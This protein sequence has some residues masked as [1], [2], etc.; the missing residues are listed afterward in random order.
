MAAR[1]GDG[2]ARLV[3]IS[4]SGDPAG[5]DV[6]VRR[7][8]ES[9]LEGTAEA[10]GRITARGATGLSFAFERRGRIAYLAWGKGALAG[11]LLDRAIR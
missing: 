7:M 6:A 10:G 4:L 9:N 5:L 11:E 8:F 2:T 3:V 1:Y